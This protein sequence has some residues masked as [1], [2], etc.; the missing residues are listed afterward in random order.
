MENKADEQKAWKKTP[1]YWVKWR[2]VGGNLKSISCGGRFGDT[3]WG[4]SPGGYMY[5]RGDLRNPWK[6]VKGGKHWKQVALSPY[7]YGGVWALKTDGTIYYR[8]SSYGG[9]TRFKWK[10]IQG[11]LENIGMCGKNHRSIWGTWKG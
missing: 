7:A 8:K 5:Y 4:V 6:W 1:A 9:A 3:C 2:P 11:W 10:K